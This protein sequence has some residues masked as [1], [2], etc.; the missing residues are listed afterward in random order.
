MHTYTYAVANGSKPIKIPIHELK[1]EK[2]YEATLPSNPLRISIC[3][4]TLLI[5]EPVASTTPI[6][7]EI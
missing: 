6:N 3:G 4:I 1:T 7:N 2:G 5:K